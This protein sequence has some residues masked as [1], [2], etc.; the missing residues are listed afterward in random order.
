MT[1]A[2]P[3]KKKLLNHSTILAELHHG[4]VVISQPLNCYSKDPKA[5]ARAMEVANSMMADQVRA[6]T[7]CKLV[8]YK[9]MGFVMRSKEGLITDATHQSRR[10]GSYKAIASIY[11]DRRARQV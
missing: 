4:F 5:V 11:V 2:P 1:K 7:K 6:G 10:T 9:G 3:T 8:Q